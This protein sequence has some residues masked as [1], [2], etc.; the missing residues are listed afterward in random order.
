MVASCLDTGCEKMHLRIS[1]QRDWRS[2][3]TLIWMNG[4]PGSTSLYGLFLEHGPFRVGPDGNLSRRRLTWASK[5]NI[6]YID[7]PVGTGFSF[8]DSD[9]GYAKN[10][11]DVAR[12]LYE[13]SRQF[14]R[15]FPELLDNDLYVTGESY[16]GK[17][18]PALAHKIH[19]ENEKGN[20]PQIPLKGIAIGDGLCDPLNQAGLA[21][22]LFDTGLLDNP[23][24]KKLQEMEVNATEAVKNKDWTT[25]TDVSSEKASSIQFLHSIT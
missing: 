4:G 19:T 2:A 3:P 9:E 23:D 24:R 16:A 21:D 12:D 17:Y 10:Q 5:Y 25:A 7:Q 14:Y 22:F 6:I 1:P 8:T 15:I 18:V 20:K 13:F 11:T